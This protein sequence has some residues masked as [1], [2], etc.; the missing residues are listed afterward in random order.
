MGDLHADLRAWADHTLETHISWVFL[1]GAHAYKVKKPVDLGFV[2]FSSREK[3]HAAC[4]SELRVN[5]RL[6]A[7]VYLGI[8]PIRRERGRYRIIEN[9]RTSHD[10]P[11]KTLEWA[12]KM[13][14]LAEND[15]ADH[16]LQRGQL[17]DA[18]ILRMADHIAAF[19]AT[20][21][22]NEGIARYGAPLQIA[23]NIEENFAQ[24][25][26]ELERLIGT[27]QAESLRSKQRAFISEYETRL[28]RRMEEGRIRDTHGDL[29]LEHVYFE[30]D[31]IVIIDAIE[32]NDRYRYGDTCSDVA[33][34][35]MDLAFHGR[36]D[37]AER[38][39]ARYA[40]QSN[41]YDIYRVLDFYESYRAFVRGKVANMVANAAPSESSRQGAE[42]EARRY[43][44]LALASESRAT[45]PPAVIAVGGLIASGKTT[46]C[47]LIAH[48]LAVPVVST[49]RTRKHMLG[50]AALQPVHTD[51][52]S[53]AYDPN[54]TE[55]VYAETIARATAVL[56]SGRP[57]VMDGSY[58]S[59]AM[60][61]ATRNLAKAHGVPYLFIECQAPRKECL[62]RLRE[63]AKQAS[64]S[65][66]REEVYDAFAARWE[67]PTELPAGTYL[68]L[69]TTASVGRTLETLAAH[70]PVWVR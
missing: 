59:P 7:D 53:G 35:A 45:L 14:R 47:D 44:L 40:R 66:G 65:D 24:I 57:V 17:S 51:S 67:P 9:D 60:R 42:I 26:R 54:F 68:A 8:V 18:Q 62:R 52:W 20:T 39:I 48:T 31:R 6:A 25:G 64:V 23:Q 34:L 70:C 36:P 46:I 13:R 58:R 30:D 38:F 3:R 4:E 33:F 22:S 49:D 10:D 32:F 63:R 55:H 61:A 69:D 43:F 11:G 21:E 41:D 2:D 56:E 19:H 5:R 1:K 28:T 15:R 29:R 50:V 12:V 37:A 16:L 27:S